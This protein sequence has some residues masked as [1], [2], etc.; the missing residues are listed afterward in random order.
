MLKSAISMYSIL[1]ICKTEAN[2]GSELDV[3]RRINAAAEGALTVYRAEFEA[4]LLSSSQL[5]YRAKAEGWLASDS[6]SEYLL[7]VR[8][9][10]CVTGHV[11]LAVF[12]RCCCCR[13]RVSV[14]LSSSFYHVLL[15]ISSLPLLFPIVLAVP[16]TVLACGRVLPFLVGGPAVLTPVRVCA[17]GQVDGVYDAESRRVDM[18]MHPTTRPKLIKLCRETFLAAFMRELLER[19]GSGMRTILH[20]IP[21]GDAGAE[22]S[23]GAGSDVSTQAPLTLSRSVGGGT[24]MGV[25]RDKVCAEQSFCGLD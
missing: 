12:P 5:Y 4:P 9:C 14:A 16:L 7:K 15:H 21:G 25:Q 23:A 6:M 22:A 2:L 11:P 1:D 10:V 17:C 20:D 13:C 18:M 3:E 19:E 24:V 8:I